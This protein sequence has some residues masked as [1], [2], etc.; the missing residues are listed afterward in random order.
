MAK[1]PSDEGLESVM[2]DPADDPCIPTLSRKQRLLGFVGC[3]LTGAFCLGMVT[4]VSMLCDHRP[5]CTFRLSILKHV[6][7][8]C[9]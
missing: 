8:L 5:Y 4:V 2:A 7:L 6:N 9:C 3:L 1:P